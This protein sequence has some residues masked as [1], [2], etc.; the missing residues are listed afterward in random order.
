MNK[1]VN[2]MLIRKLNFQT[3]KTWFGFDK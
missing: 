2:N 3:G 1:I